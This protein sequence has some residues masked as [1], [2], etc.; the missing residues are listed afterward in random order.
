MKAVIGHIAFV[1][2]LAFA[3]A[4]AAMAQPSAARTTRS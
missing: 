2:L 4:L 1:V 3:G